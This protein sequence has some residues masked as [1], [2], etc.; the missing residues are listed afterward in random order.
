[1]TSTEPT[2]ELIRDFAKWCEQWSPD[3]AAAAP[4]LRDYANHAEHNRDVENLAN[5]IYSARSASVPFA[6]ANERLRTIARDQAKA[7]LAFQ[8]EERAARR[9]AK[10]ERAKVAK[11]QRAEW[12]RE[13]VRDAFGVVIENACDVTKAKLPNRNH[14]CPVTPYG[15]H[16]V[17]DDGRPINTLADPGADPADAWDRTGA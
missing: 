3:L 16:F 8:A 17:D 11:A 15:E 1:M 13:A 9:L 5:V 12:T 14:P 10:L 7:V 6:A 4:L 2:P